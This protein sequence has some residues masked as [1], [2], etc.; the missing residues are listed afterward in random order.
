M[1]LEATRT[2]SCDC[3]KGAK[4]AE[5]GGIDDDGI[6]I[7]VEFEEIDGVFRWVVNSGNESH[8]GRRGRV[9]LDVRVPCCAQ[10]LS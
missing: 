2:V 10:V 1:S 9:K 8:E 5:E 4:M 7:S 3:C 6:I